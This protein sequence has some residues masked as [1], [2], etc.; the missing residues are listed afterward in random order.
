MTPDIA[1]GRRIYPGVIGLLVG[2]LVIAVLAWL[3]PGGV[4]G[5]LT[6]AIVLVVAVFALRRAVRARGLRARGVEDFGLTLAL[7]LVMLIACGLVLSIGSSVTRSGWILMLS[8]VAVASL[9]ASLDLPLSAD[10]PRSLG[11]TRRQAGLFGVIAVVLISAV[12]VSVAS[13]R[14][15]PSSATTDLWALPV[16]SSTSPAG[17]PPIKVGMTSYE[18][19]DTAFVLTMTDGTNV[20]QTWNLKLAPG[21]SW[22]ATNAANTP[23]T[24][25]FQLRVAG[26]SEVY[27]HV[28]IDRRDRTVPTAP[29][30]RGSDGS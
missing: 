5:G 25:T 23:A 22:T 16:A 2:F 1:T 17:R 12:G 8:L 19:D 11:W 3:L 20:L 6:G 26:H 29:K 21:Q 30:N 28:S 4:L 10:R 27:R 24:V 9:L 13:V 15:V 18:K 7:A 14:S